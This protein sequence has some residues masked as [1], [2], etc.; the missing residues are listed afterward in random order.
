MTVL[1]VVLSVFAKQIGINNED[2]S[3]KL[4]FA[5]LTGHNCSFQNNFFTKPSNFNVTLV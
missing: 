2:Y 5:T 3:N 4:D 1:L